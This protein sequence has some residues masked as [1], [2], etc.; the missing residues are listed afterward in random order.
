M[1]DKALSLIFPKR[2]AFCGILL[3]DLQVEICSV[4]VESAKLLPKNRCLQCGKTLPHCGCIQA[5]SSLQGVAGAFG[6][7][8]SI[9][10]AIHRFKF[11]N[12]PEI[13]PVLSGFQY[14]Q[15]VMIWENSFDFVASIPMYWKKERYR[16]Y[17]QSELL[18]S[19]LAEWMALPFADQ[20]LKKKKNH[21]PLHELSAVER[22]KEIAATFSL[23][24][25]INAL[26]GKRVLLVDDVYTTGATMEECAKVL[27][28][29]GV[30]AI[31]GIVVAAT[32]LGMIS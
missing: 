3:V 14:E 18:A 21:Q 24:K 25:D 17:N 32:K 7:T 15:I 16:G 26:Q 9:K 27:E 29:A 4:C 23:G 2:C 28:E 22:K 8:G 12:C 20:A 6:Y 30:G 11:R 19:C 13:A 31:S 1:I 10:N 5:E